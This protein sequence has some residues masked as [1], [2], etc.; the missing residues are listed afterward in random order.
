MP[1]LDNLLL[2]LHLFFNRRSVALADIVRECN[3]SERTGFR[4]LHSLEVAGF[5]LYYDQDCK[6]YR[7]ISKGGAMAHLTPAELSAVYLGIDILESAISPTPLDV[8]RRVK[9]KL[10]SFMTKPVQEGLSS[11]MRSASE[12]GDFSQLREQLIISFLK[13]VQHEHQ[14][15]RLHHTN[16]K[17]GIV[18]TELTE[19]S[20]QFEREWKLKSDFDLKQP[21]I[22]L[23]DIVDFELI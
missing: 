12:S 17:D 2:I 21:A 1:K 19:P 14:R 13:S 9:L 5:P 15:I 18:T 20:L 8:F 10:G 4:Y 3:I 16:G 6:G 22:K 7:L 11:L 23:G